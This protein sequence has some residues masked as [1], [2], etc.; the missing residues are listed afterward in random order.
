MMRAN[1]THEFALLLAINGREVSSMRFALPEKISAS[2]L[3][4][5]LAVSLMPVAALAQEEGAISDYAMLDEVLALQNDAFEELGEF[6]SDGIMT[7][8]T[9]QKVATPTQAQIRS[10][11]NSKVKSALSAA[12]YVA[13]PSAKSPY[14]AGSLSSTTLN[15]ALAMLNYVRYIAGI[16][17]N[18][19]L[20]DEYNQSAQAAALVNAANYANTGNFTLSHYPNCPTGMDSNLYG[21]GAY[22]ASHSNLAAGCNSPAASVLMY[23]DDSDSSNIEAVGHRRWCLNPDMKQTG[24]GYVPVQSSYW[25]TGFSAMWSHDGSSFSAPSYEAVAWPAANMPTELFDD[26]QAWSVSLDMSSF[27]GSISKVALKRQADGKIWNLSSGSSQG[28]FYNYLNG[29][30]YVGSGSCVIFRP[31]GI[32]YAAR[33]KFAVTLTGANGKTYSYTVSFFDVVP[34]NS[35]AKTQTMYRLYNPNSGE[36]FYTANVNEKN[37][38]VGVGWQYEGTAWNAPTSGEPVYRMYNPNV[39]DHHYTPSAGE[40]DMLVKAGWNYEGICWYSH[41]AKATPLYRL[42]NPNA[43][44][45]SHHY[46]TSAGERDMLKRIGWKDEGVG[47]YGM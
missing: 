19:T 46:T 13:Q 9:S 26:Q 17:S 27:G 24:F 21:L 22:G 8:A 45:G 30:S 3:A 44:T 47:W 31:K 41:T 39:G 35:T 4:A 2:V 23:M 43:T 25:S 18:I 42:Y 6:D 32:S 28:D 15:N 40:R 14:K 10:Y 7:L 20:N 38:L 1:Q 11:Y 5:M 33:D 16:P 12:T 37:M 36:H 34:G 29:S